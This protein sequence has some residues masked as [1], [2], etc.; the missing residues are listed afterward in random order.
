MKKKVLLVT[1]QAP[2]QSP[3]STSEKRPPIGIGFLISVLRNAGHEVFFI[4]N[5]LQPT[6]FLETDYLQRNRIEYVGVYANTICFR[7]TLRMLHRLEY[8]RRCGGWRGKI[9]V[10]GPHT[11]V[12][13]D[14]IPDFVDFVV[15]G[16]GERAVLDIVEDRVRERVLSYPRIK[17][18]DNLPMP[19]WDYFVHMQYD[20]GLDWFK[21]KPVFTMNTSRGCPF[22]CT[23][24]S[25][26]SIWGRKYT[27]FSA[28]RIV[29]DIEH[30]AEQYGAKGIYF[31][32]D[33]FTC[34]R[35]RL[36]RFCHLMIERNVNIPW[37][38]ETRADALDRETT[39]LMYQAGARAFYIGVESGSQRMLDFFKKGV[40]LEQIRDAF[41][42]C[43]EFGIKT[44]ASII[45]G[46]PTETEED[47]KKTFALIE[48]IK[49]TVTWPNVF[50]GI[51]NSD[52]CQ[53]GV[54]NRLHEFIDDRG[55]VYL[56]GHN[57]RSKRF[58][59]N[60]WNA[61]IP[62]SFSRPK[63]SVVLST[64]NDGHYLPIAMD[65]I[66]KQ[67]FQDFEFIIVDD[68]STDGTA[69]I[70]SKVDDPRIKIFRNSQNLGLT[71]SLNL[72]I[73]HARGKYI[74]R[75]DADD[76]SLPHRLET[77]VNFLDK[78]AEYALIG[79]SYYRMDEKG[80][81]NSLLRVLEDDRSIKAGLKRQNWFAHGSVMMRRD[82]FQ[83]VGG[84]DERFK[85][86]QD[87]DLWLR[88]AKVYKVANIGEPLY[89]W[90][91]TESSITKVR[92]AEQQYYANLAIS[93]AEK[94]EAAEICPK[95]ADPMVSVIVP[96]YNRP[97]M[98]VRTVRS[99]L[100]QTYPN[101]EII[102]VNDAGVD[103][104]SV[105]TSLDQ[106]GNIT[107][108]KHERNR[109]LAA[110][111]NTG[112]R[113]ARGKYIAYL[114]DDDLFYPEH[115]ETLVGFLESS[116]GGIAYT[117]AFR[118]YQI[119]KGETYQVVK[120]DVPFSCDFDAKEILVCNSIPVLCVMHEKS[121]LDQVGLF[122]ESLTTHE[123]WDLWIRMSR[124]FKF[125]HI[126]KVTCEYSYREDGTT[127][128]SG[129][130]GDFLKTL[131][132]IYEKY[133]EYVE[134]RP[135]LIEAQRRFLHNLEEEVRK[136][137]TIP[138]QVREDVDV[139]II[140]PVFNKLALTR[141]CL[142]SIRAKTAGVTYEI[143]VV[144]NGSTDGSVDFL[145][146]EEE[147]GRLKAIVNGENLGFARACNQGARE[148]S[149]RTIL[150]LNNDTQVES[151]WLPPLLRILDGDPTVAA[152]GSK[153][154]F[155]DGTLQHAGIAIIEDRKLPDPLVAKL[156][157][158]RQPSDLPEANLPRQYQALT[159]ACLLIRKD[160][161][162]EVKGFDEDYWNG[163]EDVDLCF[164]L[165]ERGW[166]L[167]YQ[168]ESVVIHFE[169]Q[170]GPE[171][172]AQ[173]SKNISRLH[174]KWLGKVK[175]DLI[176]E[177]DG[178]VRETR[179]G[180]ISLYSMAKRPEAVVQRS[181]WQEKRV[182]IIILTFNQLKYTRRC[183]ESIQKQTPESHEIIFVDNGSKDGTVK[184]L[185]QIV[186]KNGNY[187]L[188]ENGKNL[189]FAKGCNQGILASTGEYILLLNN[190]VIVTEGWL[191][192]MLRCLKS[193]PDVGIVG[194]MTNAISGPQRVPRVD[195]GS[196]DR[197][198][199]YARSFR[200]RNLG[201]RI[202]VRRIVGFCM[203][204]RRELMEKIG[205][206]DEQFGS[207]N[208]EDDDFCLRASLE[209]YRNLIAG[210]V[211]IHHYGSRSFVGNGINYADALARNRRLFQEKWKR[212]DAKGPLGVKLLTIHLMEKADELN[213]K[214][215]VRKAVETLSEGIARFPNE[216]RLY[217]ML[218]EILIDSKRFEEALGVLNRMPSEGRDIWKL[219][220][221]AYCEEGLERHKEAEEIT[222]L[223][224]S[225]HSDSSFGW[226]LKGMVA[227]RKG[228]KEGA[229]SFFRKA[230]TLDPGYGEPY[231]NLGVLKWNL[232]QKEEALNLLERGVILSP[233][234]TDAITSY[235]QTI[236]ERQNF[237]R[238][239]RIF[240]EAKA[241]YPLN[242]RIAFLLIDLLIQQ[243]KNDAAMSEI[244]G[245]MISFG[246]DDGIL[247]AAL[248]MRNRLGA[249][250][251][252]PE[253]IG[254]VS[255]CMIVR[256]EE[257]NLPR[258]LMSVKSLVDEMILVDTGSTDRTREIARA[259]GAKVYDYEW[260]DDFS[261]AR[262][263][264]L[265][266]ATGK[267]IFILDA[268]EVISEVDRSRLTQIVKERN[269]QP[270]AY[271][272]TTRNYV[273][274][275]NISG[276]T[277]NDGR[278]NEEAG[279]GWFPGK[280]VRLFPNDRRIHFEH[281]VHELVEHSLR[282]AGIKIKECSVPIHH[283]GK[284]N[285]N[286]NQKKGEA[287]F[288]L[289]RKKLETRGM[290]FPSLYELAVQAG[291]LGRYMEAAQLWQQCIKLQS[292]NPKAHFNL[293]YAYLKLGRYE[294][295]RLASARAMELDPNFKEAAF[296]YSL[297]KFCLGDVDHAI[298]TLE[299]LIVKE[300]QYPSAIALLS[301][302]YLIGGKREQA[303]ELLDQMK[304][305]GYDG[306]ASLYSFAERLISAGRREAAVL[307]L[308]RAIETQNMN[309]QIGVLLAQC[310]GVGERGI[311]P[312]SN[313]H[314]A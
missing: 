7:D 111:R 249:K 10:G 189:G 303:L 114:D 80:E 152:V 187:R 312:L 105:V 146:Q 70:L 223:V 259:F 197:L 251:I 225:F 244:E 97:E 270:V 162:D 228:D 198:E 92:S 288:L 108:V 122:D 201:R 27:F 53:Y 95:L 21:E 296:N 117:D 134:D 302:A 158:H 241:L 150:F 182:S 25:V 226:N 230:M 30:L 66:L 286:K 139:S 257:E 238:G 215:Q 212:H 44:G 166:R 15:Q 291:E 123:D 16:E 156:L 29:S 51:P 165:R 101:V 192:G 260:A 250:G 130:R 36:I 153:L 35:E 313:P 126:Q 116:G 179:A 64:Y 23:F 281:P 196:I 177:K 96:T 17:L 132:V 28:E 74:A 157:Y 279:T 138:P 144:D 121:C 38:C 5:Y 163:Y 50:V 149:G 237:E 239:E 207:G 88:M 129:R 14:T 142:E 4:D 61:S 184:W 273:E 217:Q 191:G 160:A 71:K 143:I 195:Y 164:K 271:S 209:G 167:V 181:R 299:G 62:V 171:R 137:I 91:F 42:Y 292:E 243:G 173:I 90:R 178:T 41:T 76:I 69:D 13:L 220:R 133:R 45:I 229:E 216:R 103:V 275:V 254:T 6:D 301:A 131:K 57:D 252:D 135:D 43:R 125:H 294:D 308:E 154:L 107:Y 147:T 84:Y 120:R 119:K 85:F 65:S 46:A 148:A 213:Q 31:R 55:L 304:N 8:L 293:G 128:S 214:D 314:S 300:P 106:K 1:S 37:A 109:G 24:C 9:M 161:F 168:P 124:K 194:P 82:A 34:S 110:A 222:D 78:N 118:A 247:S 255:L 309:D 102:V 224:L 284:L 172:F 210:D 169:S 282:R 47:V 289:G 253:S 93:E 295:A 77:Q 175:P 221:V 75:M 231:T 235:H 39:A 263:F 310:K 272:L 33:N 136:K 140:I 185:R 261:A 297:C 311:N 58:Y 56:K 246:I 285:M 206:L 180:G 89:C 306:P 79:S 104:E 48:E 202:P 242:R 127:M 99:I 278:Y 54:S 141:Q 290:D 170:S 248:E 245:A 219:E 67:T 72:G 63:V 94:R 176:I 40:T 83:Q 60:R 115:I 87:Y 86:A 18:L 68:A 280:K 283:Y 266:K 159:A 264:S 234:L 240:Q 307:L 100:N 287:Y 227:Y 12:A 112:I 113:L 204:F 49:P 193:A 200:E 262:N 258:S 186:K 265:S 32:E 276:W 277:A 155:P 81:I 199:E 274:P 151:E 145:R 11:T 52:L 174:E 205:Y 269:A 59:G 183:I 98:L 256:N 2:L 232:D 268:D 267:W 298:S 26:G 19:A 203:L 208:F 236:I 211:F 305:M 190:D 218:S 20:W 233:T 22:H 188:I 3:F 73:R